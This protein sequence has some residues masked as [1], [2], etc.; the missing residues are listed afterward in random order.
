MVNVDQ[1]RIYH[2]RERD[3]GVEKT[4]GLDG[5]RSKA[6][7]VGTESSKGLAREETSRK[8]QWRDK[9]VRS[10][11]S[12]EFSNNYKRR[13]IRVKGGHQCEGTGENV[14]RLLH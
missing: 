1:V 11:G 9:R 5:E 2:P 13:G 6:E 14:V 12:I 10:E 7:Q 3:E 4:D 8:K